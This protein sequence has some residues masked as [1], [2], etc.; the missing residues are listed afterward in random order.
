MLLELTRPVLQARANGDGGLGWNLGNSGE[1]PLHELYLRFQENLGPV[2][3]VLAILSGSKVIPRAKCV[4]WMPWCN[5]MKIGDRLLKL[6]VIR[7]EDKAYCCFCHY[8]LETMDHV[9][10]LCLVVWR[11]WRFLL[12]WFVMLRGSSG[13]YSYGIYERLQGWPG[14]NLAETRI[15]FKLSKDWFHYMAVSDDRQ[16]EMPLP[17]DRLSGRCQVLAYP[18]AVQL[19]NPVEPEFKGQVDDKYEYSCDIEDLKV[20]GWRCTNPPIGFWQITPSN[21]FRS[22]GPLK[23]ELS[24]HVGPTNLAMFLSAHYAGVD[25]VTS[26]ADGEAWKKVFG[27]VFIYVNSLPE[28]MDIGWLWTDAK[29]QMLDEV[30]NW[31]YWFPASED[32]PLADQRGSVRGILVVQ[33][34]YVAAQNV[35]GS[36]AYVGLAPPGEA[37]S[38]QRESKGYQFWTRADGDGYFSINNVRPGTYNLYAWVPGFIGEYHYDE[39]ISVT[40]GLLS[41]CFHGD[42]LMAT[43][44]K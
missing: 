18:E 32:F 9:F 37:G 33:D 31:P 30:D 27:P 4:L 23:Q 42:D 10:L 40:P 36:G 22:G 38:W 16:R 43:L 21:E 3:P 12:S 14:F 25:I 1:F 34:H 41:F 5:R 11:V 15:A 2:Y 8:P 7:E 35:P 29:E 44:L 17:D 6:G 28:G 39:D 13:F 20:H 26:F 19:T 24:S